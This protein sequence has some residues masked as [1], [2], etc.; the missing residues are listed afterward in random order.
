MQTA[1]AREKQAKRGRLNRVQPSLQVG[2]R[3]CFGIGPG[4]ESR[5][6]TDHPDGLKGHS[7][8][9]GDCNLFSPAGVL[10]R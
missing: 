9:E 7:Q 2:H 8:G 6:K 4:P 1:A 5:G 3:E 10:N